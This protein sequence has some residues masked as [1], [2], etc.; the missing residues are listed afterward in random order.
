MLLGHQTDKAFSLN[1]IRGLQ[2]LSHK[3]LQKP[4]LKNSTLDQLIVNDGDTLL[5]QERR[6]DAAVVAYMNRYQL[7]K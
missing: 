4:T 5:K 1:G 3:R 7:N 6:F 2:Y